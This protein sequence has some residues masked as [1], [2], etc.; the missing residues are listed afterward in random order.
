MPVPIP[1]V[2]GTL[3]ASLSFGGPYLK[4]YPRAAS[5][6]EKG[7][8]QSDLEYGESRAQNILEPIFKQY[9]D[10]DTVDG[11]TGSDIPVMV[12]DWADELAAA[13]CVL[14]ASVGGRLDRKNDYKGW[15][16]NVIQEVKEWLRQGMPILDAD[17]E[18]IDGRGGIERSAAGLRGP[19][20][21]SLACTE[22][23]DDESLRDLVEYHGDP[24][25]TFYGE[26]D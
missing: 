13:Y 8:I 23:F 24:S 26:D 25:R 10:V 20:V 9:Y 21:S 19:A 1:P 16:M 3:W 17:G 12:S 14:I 22:V 5:D 11:W 7:I 4:G 2:S 15:A 6:K 18:I